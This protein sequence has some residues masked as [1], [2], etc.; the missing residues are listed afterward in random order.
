M[1]LTKEI[2][3]KLTVMQRRWWNVFYKDFMSEHSLPPE[4]KDFHASK[5]A[6]EVIAHN[7]ALLAVWA[8]KDKL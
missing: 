1:K 7:H 2:Y 5:E 4:N 6:R 8:L 3:K